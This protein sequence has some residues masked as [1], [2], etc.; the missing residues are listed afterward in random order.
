MRRLPYVDRY[1]WRLTTLNYAEVMALRDVGRSRHA[2]SHF[3]DQSDS[4]FT[5]AKT[6]GRANLRSRKEFD[7]LLDVQ[8]ARAASPPVTPL[9]I[10]H[11]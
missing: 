11:A 2:G 7:S 8:L 6:E 10:I 4:S 5:D 3:P 1:G 9:P